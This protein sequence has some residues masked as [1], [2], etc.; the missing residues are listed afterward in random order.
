M[1]ALSYCDCELVP[2]AHLFLPPIFFGQ[3]YLGYFT[4]RP[5]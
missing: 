4:I 1:G 2:N 5:A 3:T